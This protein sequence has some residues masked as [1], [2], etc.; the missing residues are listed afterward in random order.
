MLGYYVGAEM[1][2]VLVTLVIRLYNN[3]SSVYV[4]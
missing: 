2:T 3:D 4:K 1:K